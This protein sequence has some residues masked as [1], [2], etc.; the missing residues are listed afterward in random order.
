MGISCPDLDLSNE[1]WNRDWV[2][3]SCYKS[4]VGRLSLRSILT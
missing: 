1:L 3:G 2:A 4:L